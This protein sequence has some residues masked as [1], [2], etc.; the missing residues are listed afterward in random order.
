MDDDQAR[1]AV[2]G[3]RT[4]D[5][6]AWRTLYDAYAERVWRGVA[7][8]VGPHPADVADIVQET[9]LAAAR[10]ARNFDDSKGSLWQWLWGIARTQV[11]L[12]YRNRL[13]Q[14]RWKMRS[15]KWVEGI[16]PMQSAELESAEL[17]E[18]VRSAL[19]ELPGD[20]EQLLTA[21]YLDGDS[22]ERIAGR[23]RLTE[24]A[25]RSK[26]ARARDAFRAAYKRLTRTGQ[27][28]PE[29]VRELP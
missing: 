9:M 14:D 23:E 12:H 22:V 10:S 16:E 1:L 26:L 11:S 15:A 28:E 2:A 7:R 29:V 3:L 6:D 17:A 18:A 5:P 24:T 8:S 4:G 21:K 13:R 25:V 27:N 19:G 20:Y